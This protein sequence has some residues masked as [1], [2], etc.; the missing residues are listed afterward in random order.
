MLIL[1]KEPTLIDDPK[2]S[3]IRSI[4]IQKVLSFS[5]NKNVYFSSPT[6][7]IIGPPSAIDLSSKNTSKHV[8]IC[9]SAST[10]PGAKVLEKLH[11]PE[12]LATQ[13]QPEHLRTQSQRPSIGPFPS[14]FVSSWEGTPTGTTMYVKGWFNLYEWKGMAHT[15]MNG[16]V[17]DFM[18]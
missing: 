14:I 4:P 2:N 10:T 8:F 7:K 6:S 16:R 12:R 18:D 15:Y 3:M 1:M 5:H 11:T 9:K 13:S 17:Y